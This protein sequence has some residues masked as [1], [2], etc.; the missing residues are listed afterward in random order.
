MQEDKEPFFDAIDNL[1]ICLSV[2]EGLI[3]EMIFNISSMNKM[4]ELG[5]I[6]A[7]DIAD[8]L[9]R[10]CNIPF[11][12]AHSITGKVV[13]YAEKNNLTLDSITIDEYKKIDKRIT[14]NILKVLTLKNSLESRNSYGA[15]APILV[16]K[17]I[18]NARSRW[19]K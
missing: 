8:F 11:R 3:K 19:L 4:A 1:K 15:T 6:I 7:T 14:D 17:A 12:D 16:K 9:V 10:E 18:K 13:Q 2:A 5:Y